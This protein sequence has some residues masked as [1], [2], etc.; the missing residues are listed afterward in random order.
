METVV[1][2]DRVRELLDGCT[3]EAAVFTTY[4]FE[5]EFF[6]LEVIPLLLPGSIP[7]S[8]DARVKQ[9][10]VRE[11]LR[12]TELALEVFFDLKIFRQEG[13]TSPAMEYLFHGVHLGNNAFHPKVALILAYDPNY[14][15]H[16]LLVGA[17]SNN[18]TRAGWWDN[19]ECMHW[20]VVWQDEAPR[21]FLNQ[22]RDDV[23]WLQAQRQLS[24]GRDS[25]ALDRIGDFLTECRSSGSA[26]S[27]AYYELNREKERHNLPNFLRKQARDNFIY[28]NWTLEII[29]PFFAEDPENDLADFFDELGVQ[30]IHILLPQD[31]EGNALCSPAYFK[32]INEEE[33][34]HWARWRDD[35]A[36]TLG[37]KGQVFRRLH[38][39]IYHFYNQK[40]SWVFVGSV[41][42]SRK[43]MY[44]NSEAGFFTKLDRAGS[45]LEPIKRLANIQPIEA[46]EL[47]PGDDVDD[48]TD[49]PR[50]ALAYDWAEQRLQGACEK[51][52]GYTINILTPE[53]S[54]AIEGFTVTGSGTQ[55]EGDVAALETLLRNGSLVK[56]SG[57]NT[58]SDR[59]FPSHRVMLQQTGWTHKPMEIPDLT[60]AQILAIYADLSPERREQVAL[61]EMIRK[62][63][64]LGEAG[65]LTGPTDDLVVKQFFSEY[66]E[67]F[68][69]FRHFN[70]RLGELVEADNQKQLAYY[71]SG[72]GMD[73][74]PVLIDHICGEDTKLDSVTT[75]LMLLC[76]QEIYTTPAYA[77]DKSTKKHLSRTK[78]A[79]KALKTGDAICI[80]PRPGTS[81]K[82]FFDWFEKQFY[83][84]YTPRGPQS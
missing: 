6:E 20:E 46:L 44:D 68:H 65:D 48:D 26:S 13:S 2:S 9:F 55:W 60:P 8:S 47:P 78:Q 63:V 4:T 67:I 70:K 61:N 71:L 1:V 41:N 16:C 38:A 35:V 28:N 29:S 76:V 21:Q 23:A 62:L 15:K 32:R 59:P 22:L 11:K 75:Y 25:S 3:V 12:T 83:A 19:I 33:Y 10:Q 17:G 66:A 82:A 31:V 79:I 14:E 74:L 58:R 77:K 43:A 72:T 49:L 84:N 64:D 37:T 40:Q 81:R 36:T 42:F 52:Q 51:N 18:L 53:G 54:A 39:K 45:L 24:G 34:L 69:A 73:S 50:I 5:P 56:I 7:Y 27:V 80:E 57:V 30:E